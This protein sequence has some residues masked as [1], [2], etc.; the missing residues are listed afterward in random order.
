[1][2]DL[3]SINEVRLMGR[4]GQDPEIKS[5]ANGSKVANFSLGVSES[6][7]DKNTGERK[8]K[9]QW[10]RIVV[11][12]EGLIGILEKQVSKGDL[13]I[14]R[15]QIETRKWEADGKTNYATEVVLKGYGAE[16]QIPN[17]KKD[18]N[19]AASGSTSGPAVAASSGKQPDVDD[20]IPF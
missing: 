6:W 7:K 13:I 2:S 10:P 14:V 17:W 8:E 12:N 9:T 16:L 3:F 15:G 19:K 4:V 20:E 18:V 11:W 1:M 5:L